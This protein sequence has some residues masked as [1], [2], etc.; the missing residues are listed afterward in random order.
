[1]AKPKAEIRVHLYTCT[2]NYNITLVVGGKVLLASWRLW[3]RKSYA[4]LA[5]QKLAKEL[6]IPCNGKICVVHGC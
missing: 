5:A 1:M 2:N 3:K 6:G 4:I